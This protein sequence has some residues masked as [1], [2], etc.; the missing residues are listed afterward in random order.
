M[1]KD[2]LTTPLAALTPEE[3]LA[4]MHA[5]DDLDAATREENKAFT[6]SGVGLPHII[7]D[8]FSGGDLYSHADGKMYDS[9]SAYKRAV[10]AAGYE[11][12]GEGIK[13]QKPKT[14]EIDWKGA[15]AETLERM[16]G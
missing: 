2:L 15:V 5:R 11:I 3:K 10:K 7:S 8:H 12:C 9:K 13:P 6:P 16:N 1:K 14:S 4:A